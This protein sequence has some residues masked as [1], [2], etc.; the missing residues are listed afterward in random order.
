MSLMSLMSYYHFFFFCSI[1][2]KVFFPSGLLSWWPLDTLELPMIQEATVETF[3]SALFGPSGKAKDEGQQEWQR[4]T[5]FEAAIQSNRVFL[6]NELMLLCSLFFCSVVFIHLMIIWTRDPYLLIGGSILVVRGSFWPSKDIFSRIFLKDASGFVA[7][8]V[9]RSPESMTLK[10][11]TITIS[12]TG[13]VQGKLVRSLWEMGGHISWD[14]DIFAQ[15]QV[16]KWFSGIPPQNDVTWVW[17]MNYNWFERTW[18]RVEREWI[19]LMWW[20]MQNI[21]YD[22]ACYAFLLLLVGVDHCKDC[23]FQIDM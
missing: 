5:L 21:E 6:L 17:R 16:V 13:E 3:A 19:W 9:M 4:E 23:S 15:F 2:F 1:L 20:H 18:S 14:L 7:G 11:G 10:C 22:L 8:A 12:I